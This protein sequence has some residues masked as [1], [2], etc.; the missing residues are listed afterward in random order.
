MEIKQRVSIADFSNDR[1]NVHSHQNLSTDSD[2]MTLKNSATPS[3]DSAKDNKQES[4][5]SVHN[6]SK[7]FFNV[8]FSSFTLLNRNGNCHFTF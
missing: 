7:V 3:T 4:I 5:D 2:T 8:I 1:L 6:E